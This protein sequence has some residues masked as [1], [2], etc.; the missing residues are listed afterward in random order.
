MSDLFFSTQDAGHGETFYG[1]GFRTP[2]R[3]T[4]RDEAD[5]KAASLNET[6]EKLAVKVQIDAIQ[7]DRVKDGGF[8]TVPSP[9]LHGLSPMEVLS[10][11]P[12]SK[13]RAEDI[14]GVQT[15]IL[16]RPFQQR[17]ERV[18]ELIEA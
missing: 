16:T 5:A 12:S 13:R 10:G 6:W 17:F 4:S 2:E 3:L 15:G 7:L 8:W 14:T 1:I 18:V 11:V 9:D